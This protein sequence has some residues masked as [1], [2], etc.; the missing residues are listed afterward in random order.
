MLV[1]TYREVTG[2]N[3][4]HYCRSS[5]YSWERYDYNFYVAN[6]KR[7]R[8]TKQFCINSFS[9]SLINHDNIF[10]KF[11]F[12][13]RRLIFF[14]ILISMENENEKKNSL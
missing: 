14:L 4:T 13:N 5:R 12:P 11:I 3:Q 9:H 7:V 2:F 6:G 1:T 10:I 8:A